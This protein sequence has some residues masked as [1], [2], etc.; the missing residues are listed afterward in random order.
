VDHRHDLPDDR[1]PGW[2]IDERGYADPR[3][4]PEPDGYPGSA[5]PAA[6][7]RGGPGSGGEHGV[8]VD[9][10]TQRYGDVS[11]YGASRGL[12]TGPGPGYRDDPA[13]FAGPS[14]TDDPTEAG[15]Y[16]T[17]SGRHGAPGPSV[18][19]PLSTETVAS[20]FDAAATPPGTG[21]PTAPWEATRSDDLRPAAGG[22][23][24]GD[25][26]PVGRDAEGG[27]HSA[28]ARGGS[29]EPE[30]STGP[31]DPLQVG[32]DAVRP[33]DR[34]GPPRPAES[35]LA[36]SGRAS[37]DGGDGADPARPDAGGGV[38]AADSAATGHSPLAGY[39]VVQPGQRGETAGPLNQPTGLVPQVDLHAPADDGPGRTGA[40]WHHTEAI[41]R[42]AVARRPG[43]PSAP[44]PVADGTDGVY[45]SRR[46]AL[47]VILAVLTLVFEVPAARLFL[48]AAVGERLSPPAILAGTFLVLGIPAFAAGL[49][50]LT[51]GAAAV[52]DPVRAWLRPPTG[53]L[54]V[55]LVLF[56]AAG[57]AVG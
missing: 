14:Q 18:E 52:G 54:T 51:T 8:P 28:L 31:G 22:G 39:P 38:H 1:I 5:R 35:L 46:P 16:P 6:G 44:S 4:Q 26:G 36:A 56:V 33:V 37:H 24:V 7:W 29:G 32:A 3:W 50:G 23:I 12:T 47:A 17:R 55:G 40:A 9:E 34:D 45:T 42:D 11:G 20:R 49:Y 43:P 27:R 53:Y 57:L 10:A 25:L 41:D 13:L 15:G 19:V 48:D 30:R 2:Q 21:H